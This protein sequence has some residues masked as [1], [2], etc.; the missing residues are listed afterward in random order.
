MTSSIYVDVIMYKIN[1]G[2]L[3]LFRNHSFRVKITTYN[4][5]K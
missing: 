4:I 3:L 2:N 5:P 1:A